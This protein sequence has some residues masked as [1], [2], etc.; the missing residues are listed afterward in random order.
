MKILHV[1]GKM[2]RGGAELRTIELIKQFPKE[3]EFH[4]CCLSGEKGTLDD[5][6]I[7]MGCK[8]HYIKFGNLKFAKKFKKLMEKEKYDVVHSHVLFVSGYI[9]FIATLSKVRGRISHFRT[10]KDIKEN[11]S[12][13]RRFRNKILKYM[14]EKYSTDILYVSY[15]AMN[16]IYPVKKNLEK[17]KVIYNGFLQRS[18]KDIGKT[19]NS[20][21]CVGRFI[22]SKNQTFLLNVL[23]LLNEKY[24]RI[25]FITFVGKNDT[26]Y[27]NKFKK[28]C[29]NLNLT[30]QVKVVGEVDNVN[31]FLEKSEYFLF[32]SKLEGLPGSL[33]EAHMNNCKIFSSNIKENIEVNN[34]YKDTSQS[35]ELSD[36]LWANKIYESM[37]E[38][39][40][41]V[42]NTE[43]NKI[44]SIEESYISLKNIYDK[45]SER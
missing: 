39:D 11:N 18:K 28:Q 34:F 12:Q 42:D 13:M 26:E 38:K 17:H 5:E 7:N 35:L 23:K 45:Y 9:N 43:I 36:E 10:S 4:F 16:S 22:E 21:V 24:H 20:F 27:G 14:I 33:I 30:N 40:I 3:Y 44:F 25:I 8:L 37:N 31:S 29:K 41:L 15:T 6:L 32:P 2:D 19:S 1:F